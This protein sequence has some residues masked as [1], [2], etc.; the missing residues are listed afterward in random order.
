M[1]TAST[2]N[3]QD[4]KGDALKSQRFQMLADIAKELSGEVVFPTYFDAVLRLR[5]ILNDPEQ[6]I[7]NIAHAVSVEPLI[8]AKLLH[9]ANSVAYN[10]GGQVLVDIKSAITR[11]G[12][13]AV[14]TA[15]LAIVM[16]Q[17]LR[18]KGMAEFSEL[19]HSLWDHSIKTAAA[20]NV[21]AS[22]TSRQNREEAMLAGLIH[23]LGAFYM[24]YRATQY[25]ELRHRPDT[26]KYLIIQW[27][28]SIGVSLLNALGIPEEIVD[29][30]IDHDRMRPT[31]T[32]IRNL[33]DTI[34]VANM[35]SGG[36]FEWLMQDQAEIPTEIAL[37]EEKYGHLHPEI[38]AM[39]SE[40]HSSFA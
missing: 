14:R 30:T 6:S 12:V 20:A 18:A 25:E 22:H 2:E 5:K 32:T 24:L 15:S 8:S 40:M 10:P 36:H 34:Y 29:A 9:L 21:I 31:P 33:S 35:L 23:D 3:D 13:N 37:L 11:L 26:V 38:E 17:L 39:A 4:K 7:A 19:T 1:M 28:E 16:T 27:H